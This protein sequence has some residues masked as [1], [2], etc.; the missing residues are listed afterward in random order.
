ME[1]ETIQMAIARLR[2]EDRVKDAE[3]FRRTRRVHIPR[4]P[5]PRDLVV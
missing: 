3:R 2:I 4:R 5:H 1:S